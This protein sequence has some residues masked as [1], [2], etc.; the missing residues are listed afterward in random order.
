MINEK[1]EFPTTR[2][3]HK[4]WFTTEESARV[5]AVN[6]TQEELVNNDIHTSLD[7]GIDFI[8]GNSIEVMI[9]SGETTVEEVELR[10]KDDCK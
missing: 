8:E 2:K 10:E 9:T 3:T 6:K 5:A 1:G 4:A 7:L